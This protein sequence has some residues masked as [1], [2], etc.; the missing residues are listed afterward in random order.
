MFQRY[1]LSS[2]VGDTSFAELVHSETTCFV[3]VG[4][5]RSGRAYLYVY[6]ICVYIY[7]ERE[8]VIVILLT[9]HNKHTSNDDSNNKYKEKTLV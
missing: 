9:V 7:I 2:T 1:S 3:F 6:I 4:H 5:A 8:R